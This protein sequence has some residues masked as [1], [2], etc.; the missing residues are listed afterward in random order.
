MRVGIFIVFLGFFTGV[1]WAD[2][3]FARELESVMR[4]LAD[5][6]RDFFADRGRCGSS[7]FWLFVSSQSK[8]GL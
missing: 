7:M 1:F 6:L 8:T 4:N 5:T 3:A 2:L